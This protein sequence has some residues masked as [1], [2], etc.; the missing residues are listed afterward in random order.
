ML[1]ITKILN[2]LL[3]HPLVYIVNS[4]VVKVDNSILVAYILLLYYIC[5][6]IKADY[7]RP[8]SP[9]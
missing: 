7:M 4:Y 8:V 1:Y 2:V 5:G 9:V 6:G 3:F